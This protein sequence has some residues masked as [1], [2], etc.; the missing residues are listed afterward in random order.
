MRPTQVLAQL[1]ECRTSLSPSYEGLLPPIL[2]PTMWERPA[3]IPA[4]VRLL[5]AYMAKGKATVQA[6]LEGVLGVFQKLLAS[7]STDAAACRL[8]GSIFA[9]FE[10]AE[11]SSFVGAIFQLCLTR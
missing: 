9:A 7:R 2:A 10:L 11:L 3:N 5:C 6:R 8:L 1:L 4:L